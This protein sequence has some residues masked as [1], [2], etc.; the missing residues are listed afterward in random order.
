VVIAPPHPDCAFGRR[1]VSFEDCDDA[2]PSSVGFAFDCYGD[3]ASCA[4]LV[5]HEVGHGFGLVHSD[6]PTDLMTPAPGDPGLR[7]QREPSSTGDNT[8]GV[9]RQSSHD[10]LVQA[11]GLS[12]T[13]QG[14]SSARRVDGEQGGRHTRISD[15]D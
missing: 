14:G 7:F 5:A 11:L 15:H 4:V 2:D 6:D 12:S 3:A 8:C 13:R 10:A 9:A 1:G